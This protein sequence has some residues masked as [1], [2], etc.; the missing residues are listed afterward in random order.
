MR[1]LQVNNIPI[2]GCMV[3][4]RDSPSDR[5]GYGYG[6]GYY[7]YNYYRYNDYIKKPGGKRK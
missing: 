4:G 3:V 1:L 5:Y 2:I 6:N 7:Y